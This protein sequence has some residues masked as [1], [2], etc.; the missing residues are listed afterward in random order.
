VSFKALFS[1]LWLV[2]EPS[3]VGWSGLTSQK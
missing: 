1:S 3:C 2:S